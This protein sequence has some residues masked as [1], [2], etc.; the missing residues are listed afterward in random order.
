MGVRRA[1]F[2]SLTYMLPYPQKLEG[3]A[4][5]DLDAAF[6]EVLPRILH[7]MTDV[8]G[9]YVVQ[10]FLEH[11]EAGER[12]G[13]TPRAQ[14]PRKLPRPLCSHLRLKDDHTC[15]STIHLCH[16]CGMYPH[17]QRNLGS[18][19]TVGALCHV[20]VRTFLYRTLVELYEPRLPP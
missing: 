2:F 14:P 11:G 12:H 4:A 20:R 16:K 10:K 15:G 13:V 8:F 7:L 18:G 6:S 9:N 19:I 1:R 5:Q 17:C 3:I